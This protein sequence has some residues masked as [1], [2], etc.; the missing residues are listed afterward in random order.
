MPTT[1]HRFGALGD[2]EDVALSD[3]RE[4]DKVIVKPGEKSPTDVGQIIDGDTN[5]NESMQ[6]GG[7]RLVQ[8]RVGEEVVGDPSTAKDQ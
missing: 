5:V 8:K 1:A 4:G 6:I 7:S 3:L 2:V